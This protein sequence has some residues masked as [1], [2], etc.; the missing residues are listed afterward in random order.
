MKTR[1]LGFSLLELMVVLAIIS[2]LAML[3]VPN[4]MKYIAKAKRTEAR[5]HLHALYMAEKDYLL[6]HGTYTSNLTGADSLQWKV[7]GSHYYTYGFK[8]GTEGV[9][10]ITGSLK[11]PASHLDGTMA[12]NKGFVIGAVGDIDNDGDPDILTI[13]QDG[14]V[15]VVKDDLA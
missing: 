12:D 2:L 7:D 3:A 10:Y 5:T 4:L 14:N 15:K 11:T 13:D 9:N 6:N 1:V 8:Q